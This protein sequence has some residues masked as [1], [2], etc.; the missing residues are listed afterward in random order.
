M[1]FSIMGFNQ[2][3]LFKDYSKLNCNDI[4]VLRTLADLISK[5]E[6]KIKENNKEYSWVMYKLLVEDLPFITQSESTMKKIVQKLIDAGLI[7]RIIVNRGGKYTYFR[8][9]DKLLELECEIKSPSNIR[10]Q[11]GNKIEKVNDVLTEEISEQAINKISETDTDIVEKAIEACRE[12][13]QVTNNYF[14]KA[15][16]IASKPKVYKKNNLRFINFQSREYDY[17]R[18]EKKLLGWEQDSDEI[19][20]YRIR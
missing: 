17:D 13:E 12:K 15:M 2:E 14:I 1:K 3:K 16:E 11:E 9:T 7:E 10:K 6:V 18:L 4:V 19:E 5:M 8:S 20:D